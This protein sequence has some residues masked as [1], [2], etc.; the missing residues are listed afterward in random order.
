[1]MDT[2]INTL[3]STNL[4]NNL[5]KDTGMFYGSL[6]QT[7]SCDLSWLKFTC[8]TF[9]FSPKLMKGRTGKLAESEKSKLI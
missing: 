2:C 1:M 3:V 7:P 6:Q 4:I 9:M 8:L 5:K